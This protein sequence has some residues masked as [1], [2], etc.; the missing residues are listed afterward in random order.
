MCTH[1]ES[2][3][4]ERTC[5]K[6]ELEGS[7]ASDLKRFTTVT[8]TRTTT[9]HTAQNHHN[10]QEERREEGCVSVPTTERSALSYAL[11]DDLDTT[12]C[13]HQLQ[14]PPPSTKQALP[15]PS[16]PVA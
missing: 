7:G 13:K 14:A 16:L 1:A 2:G 9:R 4:R 15:P 5:S 11:R 10:S 12:T 3:M 6:R 8:H